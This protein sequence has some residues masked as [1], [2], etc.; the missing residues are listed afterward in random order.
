MKIK[1]ER[2]DVKLHGHEYCVLIPSGTE[3]LWIT[4]YGNKHWGIDINGNRKALEAM[5]YTFAILGFNPRNKIIYFPIRHNFIPDTF[6]YEKDKHC[7]D[8]YDL[9]FTTDQTQFKRG[10]WKEVQKMIKYTKSK[11][12]ILNYDENRTVEY[13]KKQ[14]RSLWKLDRYYI[15][16]TAEQETLFHVYNRRHFC[17]M[18]LELH[19]FLEDDLEEYFR[20]KF[21]QPYEWFQQDTLWLNYAQSK[22]KN[23]DKLMDNHPW[24]LFYDMELDEEVTKALAEKR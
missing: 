24:I 22:R 17:Q 10:L 9:I 4:C 7:V 20:R 12:Y 6:Y 18:F 2:Y 16:E 13:F 1:F 14:I 3:Q 21:K 19:E 15:V 23:S 11:K 5:L 8:Q